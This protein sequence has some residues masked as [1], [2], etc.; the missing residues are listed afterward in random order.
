MVPAP[1]VELTNI[2]VRSRTWFPDGW[3]GLRRLCTDCGL[4][5]V[6]LQVEGATPEASPPRE[7]VRGVHLSALGSWL[8]LI[9]LDV[10]H[11]GAPAPRYA[12]CRCY[13]ALVRACAQE[14]QQAAALRPAYAVWHAYYT[15]YP[16]AFGGPRQL[17]SAPFLERLSELV[18]ETVT[19]F[20]PPFKLC[21][22]NGYGVG[23]GPHALDSTAAFLDRLR[24]VPVGLVF[25]LGH[26]LT[27]SGR[28]TS[29]GAAC[30]T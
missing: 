14:L 3:R 25:D 4:A 8:T 5:G 9:G 15:P 29:P 22:E 24:G 11:F 20:A 16:Q 28:G 18:L 6:E 21:F 10:P 17:T 30:R 2:A 12:G 26:H 1:A 27:I 19:E 13:R 23:V 7:L